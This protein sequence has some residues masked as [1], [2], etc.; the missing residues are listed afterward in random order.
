[1]DG[2][3]VWHEA[4]RWGGGMMPPWEPAK[5]VGPMTCAASSSQL[6]M[7]TLAVLRVGQP[8]TD[9]TESGGG[10]L[11]ARETFASGHGQ[12]RMSEEAVDGW[13]WIDRSL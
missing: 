13:W 10:F 6:T 2:S 11:D 8:G 3:Q 7:Y 4:K 5:K 1:M 9:G 12:G